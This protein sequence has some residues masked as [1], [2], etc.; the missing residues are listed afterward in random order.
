ME[1]KAPEKKEKK[2]KI[3]NTVMLL[4]LIIKPAIVLLALCSTKWLDPGGLKISL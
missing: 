2:E 3:I 1:R 4:Y